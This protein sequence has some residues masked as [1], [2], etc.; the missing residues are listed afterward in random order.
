MRYWQELN[1]G[2]AGQDEQQ[3]R[4]GVLANLEELSFIKHRGQE[5]IQASVKKIKMIIEIR[6]GSGSWLIVVCFV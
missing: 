5:N 4:G 3:A 2:E 1:R 6:T